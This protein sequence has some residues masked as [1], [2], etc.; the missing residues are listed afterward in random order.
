MGKVLPFSFFEFEDSESAAVF[1]V[2]RTRYRWSSTPIRSRRSLQQ[3]VPATGPELP[4]ILGLDPWKLRSIREVPSP[5]G[6]WLATLKDHNVWIRSA[7]G[8]A[9][10]QLTTDGTAKNEYTHWWA[11]EFANWS[12]IARP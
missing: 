2:G 10:M 1:N 4:A 12:L 5:D 9:E 6:R 8:D 3:V 11:T 7:T